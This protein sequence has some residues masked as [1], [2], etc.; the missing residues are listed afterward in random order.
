MRTFRRLTLGLAALSFVPAVASAQSGSRFSDSWFWGVKAG[1]MTF[2]TPRVK[3]AQAP[4]IGAEWL[5]TRTHGAL[6]VAVDQAFFDEMSSVNGSAVGIENNRRLTV[7]LFAFPKEIGMIRPYAGLGIA[8]NFIQNTNSRGTGLNPDT[9]ASRTTNVFPMMT[10]GMQFQMRRL[11]LFA[12]GS[13]MW[14]NNNF[15]INDETY[16]LEGGVR[17]NVGRSQAH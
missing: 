3:H 1:N 8:T 15:L 4:L 10:A 5:I 2:W 17:Y 13:V 9:L 6:Y 11:S 16:F 14:A 12:Q 7:S